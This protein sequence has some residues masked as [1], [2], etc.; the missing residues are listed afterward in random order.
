MAPHLRLFILL[1]LILVASAVRA[2]SEAAD[3]VKICDSTTQIGCRTQS[4]PAASSSLVAK[5]SDAIHRVLSK[6][7][8]FDNDDES[9][10]EDI[11]RIANEGREAATTTQPQTTTLK[12][13]NRTSSKATNSRLPSR[14][15]SN[16][17][18]R[19]ETSTMK[20]HNE[21][22]RAKKANQADNSMTGDLKAI[23]ISAL[24][25]L[26]YG[27]TKSKGRATRLA[28]EDSESV[29]KTPKFSS[30]NASDLVKLNSENI[31]LL[32][33]LLHE[34]LLANDSNPTTEAPLKAT[35]TSKV[36][37]PKTKGNETSS[38]SDLSGRILLL[39]NEAELDEQE[40]E[41][42]LL[43]SVSKPMSPMNRAD[44]ILAVS[45]AL[46]KLIN[47]GSQM[48]SRSPSLGESEM[49][50]RGKRWTIKP[51][52]SLNEDSS[53]QSESQGEALGD[54][55]TDAE[56][57]DLFKIK[58]SNLHS[59]SGPNQISL[60]F[61][62]LQRIRL[63]PKQFFW[64]VF[65]FNDTDN[66]LDKLEHLQISR[67]FERRQL[68]PIILLAP[69][70]RLNRTSNSTDSRLWLPEGPNL[71]EDFTSRQQPQTNSF[72]DRFARSSFT[73]N[74][75]LYA[76]L[77]IIL[78]FIFALCCSFAML[79]TRKSQRGRFDG[80]KGS[81]TDRDKDLTN[82]G[83]G[84]G[85][86]WRKLSNTTTTLLKD[87]D[88][89]IKIHDTNVKPL[90]AERLV[91]DVEITTRAGKKGFEWYS[92][93]EDQTIEEKQVR[94][95][96]DGWRDDEIVVKDRRHTSKSVQTNQHPPIELSDEW[97]Q[98][99]E[100]DSAG[101]RN[102]NTLTKSELVMLKEK[103]I[104]IAN[105]RL[106]TG[107]RSPGHRQVASQTSDPLNMDSEVELDMTLSKPVRRTDDDVTYLNRQPQ[108]L[109]PLGAKT[110]HEI[111][112]QRFIDDSLT[113]LSRKFDLPSKHET[114][115]ETIRGELSKIELRD[116][117]LDGYS[118]KKRSPNHESRN[119]S[120]LSYT[121]RA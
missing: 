2:T 112:P 65:D 25:S 4:K 102:S 34:K 26:Y 108:F 45:E 73:D 106:Q 61:F 104:P 116:R 96:N 9:G 19:Q 113:S 66:L 67:Q 35:T 90:R 103:L 62:L 94:R 86:I 15:H 60:V 29:T 78:L 6:G 10:S 40:H 11:E 63:G 64:R 118:E 100:K 53:D 31:H 23:L 111:E 47:A 92:F 7:F 18:V 75:F 69:Y 91:E 49:P 48:A 16:E 54:K 101:P 14:G 39:E 76:I 98:P 30:T 5:T 21:S 42:W 41:S 58:V 79:C 109:V 38:S 68:K 22:S 50:M 80:R 77:I 37:R 20:P 83:H 74:L 44:A 82:P 59:L 95:R 89:T 33:R 24:N 43:E 84:G 88:Q 51:S 46:L 17:K 93:E 70:R 120:G 3:K 13:K 99:I 52:S 85:A 12:P 81:K 28:D 107:R 71:P 27:Q 121:K 55:A 87:Q 32:C 119:K 117:L 56:V 97:R 57:I 1:P 72:F 114:Q 105:Q 110:D 115:V 36:I 8:I